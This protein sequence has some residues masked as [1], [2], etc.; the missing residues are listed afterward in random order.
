MK[1]IHDAARWYS[2]NGFSVIPV[3]ANKHPMLKTWKPFQEAR[4]DEAQVASWWQKWP[5]AGVAIVTGEISDLV[6]VDVDS[7]V[8]HEALREFLPDSLETPIARTPSGGYHYF[9]KYRPGLASRARAGVTDCDVRIDGGYVVAAPSVAKYEK[10]GRA[11]QGG[12]TWLDGLSLGRVEPAA[13]P[14][15]LFDVLAGPTDTHAEARSSAR[16]SMHINKKGFSSTGRQQ[17]G[18]QHLPTNDNI[19]QHLPTN[20]NIGF[21]EGARDES[22]FR[23]ANALVKGG[24]PPTNIEKYLLFFG[25][26]CSPPFPEK[27]IRA[28]IKSALSRSENTDR[29]LTQDIR[30]FVLT[31]SGNILTTFVYNCQHLTTR[32]EK[33]KANVILGRLVKEGL[34]ERVPGQAGVFRKVENECDPED[35]LSAEVRAVDLWLPFGLHDMIQIPPGSIILVAGAQDGGKSALLMNI[36]RYNMHKWKTHYFSSE[37]NAAAFKMRASKFPDFTPSEW[38][39]VKFY[40]RSSDFQDVIKTGPNDLNL[41]DYLEIHD[42]F[43]QVS[44]LMAKIHQKL[45]QS[46]AVVAL[47]KDPGS[48]NGRGGS[49]TQ[50]KPVLSI[51]LDYGK[52]TIAKFKG[53]FQGENPRGKQIIFKLINGCQIREVQG[54]HRPHIAV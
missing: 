49:F 15:M 14:D 30:D 10:G 53:Q 18:C 26:H 42:N 16:E 25:A 36:A 12:Y 51:S 24:M 20:D 23:L 9:F 41:I 33:N 22:L 11:I 13:L 27:E 46:V 40:Q 7:A 54:W 8:G 34:I 19:R 29:N 21:S 44:S 47:Q 4:A 37:L 31:T 28:K 5:D 39:A 43:Y 48:L 50:E 6:V 35:W 45:G 32:S 17:S 1:K 3:K 38:K 2:R 52:A